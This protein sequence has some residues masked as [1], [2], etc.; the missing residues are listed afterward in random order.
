[1]N[2]TD[3][4]EEIKIAQRVDFTKR[5]AT[6]DKLYSKAERYNKLVDLREDW[7]S[8][9]IKSLITHAERMGINIKGMS[10]SDSIYAEFKGLEL[11][12]HLRYEVR[13]S[14]R[15]YTIWTR[16]RI[17][18]RFWFVDRDGAKSEKAVFL[19]FGKKRL[20]VYNNL[21]KGILDMT[22]R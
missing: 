15:R 1:M 17:A 21:L 22:G 7:A 13:G 20:M 6:L 12:G 3:L 18:L 8:K 2:V 14:G 9:R 11:R 5:K 4:I 16:P 19:I 10:S